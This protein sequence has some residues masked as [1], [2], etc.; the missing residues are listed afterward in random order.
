MV[1][2]LYELNN[3]FG[4]IWDPSTQTDCFREIILRAP[5]FVAPLRDIM[6][7]N[8][9]AVERGSAPREM[10]IRRLDSIAAMHGLL[11]ASAPVGVIVYSD[12]YRL[13]G[14][15]A[16]LD[17]AGQYAEKLTAYHDA[18]KSY[19]TQRLRGKL[20]IPAGAPILPLLSRY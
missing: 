7:Y 8:I 4:D 17:T 6:Q 12:R 20:G 3:S 15:P 10:Y 18:L 19:W 1:N 11:E 5:G 13:R 16:D 14:H 2:I 9:L